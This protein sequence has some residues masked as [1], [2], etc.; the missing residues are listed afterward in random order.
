MNRREFLT[1]TALSLP[2]ILA[3]CRNL[4]S[5]AQ[6]PIVVASDY[7]RGH[8]LMND[9]GSF[10]RG[11]VQETETLIVGGGVAGLSAAFTLKDRDYR[12]L[13][14]SSN[15]GGTSSTDQFEGISLCTGA[16][17]DLAYPEN[18]DEDTLLMLEALGIIYYQSWKKCWGFSDKQHL[19]MDRRKNQ[20]YDQGVKRKD[21]LPDGLPKELFERKILDFQDK[22]PLPSRLISEEYRHLND[23]TFEQYL[24]DNV[25][26]DPHFIRCMDY[27]MMDDYGAPCSKVSALAGLS[28]FIC[29]PYYTQVVELFSPPVGNYYFVDKLV[30]SLEPENLHLN[31]MVVNVQEV[32]GYWE[33]SVADFASKSIETFK[34]ENVIYAGNKH[35]LK[36]ISPEHYPLFESNTY[37]PWLVI[38]VVLEDGLEG[39]GYW[40]NEMI[41]DD[42]T[43]LGFVDSEVMKE[44]GERVLTCYYCL[45]PESREDLVNLEANKEVIVQ[46]T[47]DYISEYFERKIDDM[48][49][50]VHMKAMGHA[51]PI[52]GTGYLFNDANAKSGGTLQFAGVDNGRLP[53]FFEAADSGILPA[54]KILATL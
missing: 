27:H 48:V 14:L 45:P 44:G 9:M 25:D 17:Y 50:G 32:N 42:P 47:L 51:M 54:K 21:V 52:P 26:P 23:I 33:A 28:Y 36:H 37:A 35:A 12:V 53:L 16:H 49:K 3:T 20:C 38:N 8:T 6:Y 30:K 43:F 34:S 13:E 24:L 15:W 7:D 10:Q 19:I 41:V 1:T 46:K 5:K 40:Q 29:R 39:Y 11:S 18:Y 22:L 2:V 4:D 31:K